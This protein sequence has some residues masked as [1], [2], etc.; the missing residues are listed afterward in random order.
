MGTALLKGIFVS[1]S[2][3][4]SRVKRYIACVRTEKSRERLQTL[5]GATE[6][7]EVLC[8]DNIRAAKEADVVILG[9]Q[10]TDVKAIL[11]DSSMACALHGKLVISML[12]GVSSA[13]IYQVLETASRRQSNSLEEKFRVVRVMPSIGAQINKSVSLI[14]EHDLDDENAT[15]VEWLFGSIGA[16]Q[17]IQEALMD[18]AVAASATTHALVVTSIDALVDGSVSR[19]IPR[20]VALRIAIEC[21]LSASSMLS[22][23]TELAELKDSMSVPRGI[24]TEAWIHLDQGH[25]RP[26]ISQTVR[27]AVDYAEGMN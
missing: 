7:V 4:E 1:T 5:F 23:G 3:A 2:N 10:P 6:A 11:D 25:V 27:Q 21:M 17:K 9:F 20:A 24:T 14:A 15:F 8:D 16:I 12:A 18:A 19:G 26:A 22:K 13:A